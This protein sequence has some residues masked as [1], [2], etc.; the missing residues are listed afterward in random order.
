MEY[1]DSPKLSIVDVRKL[2]IEDVRRKDF[3]LD[4]GH[5][6]PWERR[7]C[8]MWIRYHLETDCMLKHSHADKDYFSC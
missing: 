1:A 2:N 6:S 8:S 7:E 4:F 5:L 3:K